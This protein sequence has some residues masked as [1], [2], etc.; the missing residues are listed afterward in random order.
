MKWPLAPVAACFALGIA[1]AGLTSWAPPIPW[2]FSLTALATAAAWVDWRGSQPALAL[3]LLGAGMTHLAWTV[4]PIAPHDLRHRVPASEALATLRGTLEGTP[5]IRLHHRN[6]QVHTNSLVVLRCLTLS[7]HSTTPHPQPAWGRVL[8]STPGL[9]HTNFRAGSDVHLSGVLRRPR[10]PQSPGGFDHAAFLQWQGIH[11]ELRTA[12]M[13]DWQPT[14]GQPLPP[15]TAID[16]FQSWARTTLSRGLPLEDPATQ[17]LWAMT[18][19]WRTALTSEI[20]QVFMRSGTL[21]IFAISGLHIALIAGITGQCLRLLL[22]PRRL[23]GLLVIALCWAYTLAT[24]AQPSAIRSTL[25][26][27]CVVGGMLLARPSNVLNS[28]AAA[29]IAVLLWDPRQLFQAGFQLS[30]AVV[31]SL[32]LLA[33]PI[34]DSLVR[35]LAWDPML[36]HSAVPPWR[37][38]LLALGSPLASNLAVALAAWLGALPLGARHFHLVS[39][40]SLLANLAVV[41]LGSAALAGNLASLLAGPAAPWLSDLFNHAS[42]FFM[43][44]ML[45]ISRWAAALP[46]GYRYVESPPSAWI[47]AYYL[48]L[49]AL[50]QALHRTHPP[51][52]ALLLA[53]LLPVTIGTAQWYATHPPLRLVILPLGAGHAI[54]VRTSSG[55]V[56]LDTGD[57][58]N[59]ESVVL[60]FLQTQGVNHLRAVALT[61]GDVRHVGGAAAI[62]QNLPTRQLWLAPTSFRSSVY[63]QV[64][65]DCAQLGWPTSTNPVPRLPPPTNPWSRWHPEAGDRFARADD[66][67]Q[68]LQLRFGPTR[69]LFLADLD[70][71]GQATLRDRHPHLHADIVVL[72][73][74]ASGTPPDLAWLADLRPHTL[75]IAD[76]QLPPTA[77][78]KP[79]YRQALARLPLP[80]LYLSDRGCL[81]LH[82]TGTRWRI[83]DVQGRELTPHPPSSHGRFTPNR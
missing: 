9:V 75:V 28:L 42:W 11:F 65:V 71:A 48:L 63:R 22:V 15:P 56:L 17:L 6:H 79:D 50:P 62:A 82:W 76:A 59:A 68:V 35:A 44:C 33:P 47:L 52:P 34:R 73:P 29:A 18:L 60:P 55:D 72:A 64:L 39:F 19:G 74:P 69:V 13:D 16:R 25:M 83:L 14:P 10:G 70:R 5:E 41:P 53:L 80:T 61:H 1:L 2:L 23:T 67:C 24:G 4:Q 37:R 43:H 57:S 7:L 58:A 12:G 78:A 54:F 77:R 21:H 32:A 51:R 40:S 26:T 49:A 27:S 31:A 45:A 38:R 81:D 8:V 20:D 46:L 30:F 66:A 3:A 36:A